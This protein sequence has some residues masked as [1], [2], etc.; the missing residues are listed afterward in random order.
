MRRKVANARIDLRT[1]PQ[2]KHFFE[3]AAFVG[4]YESLSS[5]IAEA[6][7]LLAKKVMDNVD[8]SRELSS[9]DRDLLL[10]ILKNAPE[11]NAALKEAYEKV[12]K[13]C[14]INES[15]QAIYNVDSNSKLIVS[16]KGRDNL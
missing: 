14:N 1:S 10:S 11:P 7:E 6:S 2:R 13:L 3:M 15:G 5:F 9:A 4:G 8:E 16:K 12:S